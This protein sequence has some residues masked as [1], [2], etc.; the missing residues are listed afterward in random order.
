MVVVRHGAD[1]SSCHIDLCAVIHGDVYPASGIEHQLCG[2]PRYGP[3]GVIL[4]SGRHSNGI[5]DNTISLQVK[6][7]PA[8]GVVRG[9]DPAA[10]CLWWCEHLCEQDCICWLVECS[11]LG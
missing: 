6:E 7:E 8:I 4:V 10:E 9:D 5:K 2:V 1:N 3:V 11:P